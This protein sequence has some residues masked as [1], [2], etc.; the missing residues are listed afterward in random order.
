M[1]S[2]NFIDF[3]VCMLDFSVV[4]SFYLKIYLQKSLGN[5][6]KVPSSLDPDQDRR[7]V[8]PDLYP[9]CLQRLAADDIR[10]HKKAKS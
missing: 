8:G 5:I 6:I 7:V 1:H 10:S 2:I 3:N 4:A 9:N